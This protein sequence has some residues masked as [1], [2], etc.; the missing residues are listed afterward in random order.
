MS[1]AQASATGYDAEV[2]TTAGNHDNR[3]YLARRV[4]E[5]EYGIKSA[6]AVA[7]GAKQTA[8]TLRD[9]LRQAK[10]DL[11]AARAGRGE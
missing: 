10:A 6:E 3:A 9:E 5:I 1:D 2:N 7:A 4:E 8:A 11:K